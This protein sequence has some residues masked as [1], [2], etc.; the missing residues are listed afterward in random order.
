MAGIAVSWGALAIACTGYDLAIS[1]AVVQP[2]SA[3]AAVGQRFGELPGVIGFAL[4]TLA[5][6]AEPAPA[7][8]RLTRELPWLLCSV[9]VA[10]AFALSAYRLVGE[11]LGPL[12][13]LCTGA[14]SA[15]GT[16]V[17]RRWLGAGHP[18]PARVR[19]AC[20]WTVRLTLGTWLVVS[21][22]KLGWG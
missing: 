15:L 3:W 10:V 17:W 6:Y 11:R 21:L 7:R 12:A 20:A 18:L 16:R 2:A 13:L 22:L 5:L 14:G 1:R 8:P 9:A 19:R 4:A